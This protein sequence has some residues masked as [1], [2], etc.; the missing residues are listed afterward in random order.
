MLWCPSLCPLYSAI[1]A[2]ITHYEL[3]HS[4]ESPL[5][6]LLLFALLITPSRAVDLDS[7]SASAAS[8]LAGHDKTLS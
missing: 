7:G 4:H 8:I 1:K 5:L 6:T 3:K 2:K